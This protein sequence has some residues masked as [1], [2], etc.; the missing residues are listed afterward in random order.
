MQA[1]LDYLWIEDGQ[2]ARKILRVGPALS[3]DF[4]GGWAQAA[5][6]RIDRQ[7]ERVNIYDA[8]LADLLALLIDAAY[9][10]CVLG[11]GARFPPLGRVG[12]IK[13][14]RYNMRM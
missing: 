7:V 12:L 2:D 6:A 3:N 11:P 9:R 10:V 5:L 13:D 14:K 4:D 1:L 8:L